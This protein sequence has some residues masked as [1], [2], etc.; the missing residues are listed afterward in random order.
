M[1]GIIAIFIVFMVT[2]GFGAVQTWNLLRCQ[3]QS[4]KIVA[5][6]AAETARQNIKVAEWEQKAKKA[7]AR[8]AVI[9]KEAT[10]EIETVK[11]WAAEVT[12]APRP[13]KDAPCEVRERATQNLIR[14]YRTP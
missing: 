4:A 13:P 14:K 11:K 6:Y 3:R 8:T 5:Q 9:S 12:A 1:T 2:I 7:Q 10:K